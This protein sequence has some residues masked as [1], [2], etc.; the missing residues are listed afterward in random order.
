[1]FK[2]I[3]RLLRKKN[4]LTQANELVLE[5]LRE[6]LQMFKDSVKCLR[7]EEGVSVGEI[8]ARDREINRHV[9]EVRKKVLTHLVFSGAAGLETSLVMLAMVVDIERIGDHTK[10]ITYLATDYPGKFSAGKF[11]KELRDFERTLAERLAAL[12]DIVEAENIRKA[13]QLA[14]THKDMDRTYHR[15][16]DRLINEED[17]SLTHGQSAMLTLYLRYL[18]RIEGHMYN[19]ISA[20]VNPFHRIGFKVKKKTEP[21]EQER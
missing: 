14:K 8:R 3:M 18:R 6:D 13:R 2:T 15:M 5:M 19:I 4:L 1:M 7:K 9:R 16:L 17:N 11:E 12:V 10:D 21:P 20:E